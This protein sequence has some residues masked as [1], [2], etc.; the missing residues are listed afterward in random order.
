LLAD[1]HAIIE[2]RRTVWTGGTAALRAAPDVLAR[3]LPL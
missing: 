1:R 3:H 2:K